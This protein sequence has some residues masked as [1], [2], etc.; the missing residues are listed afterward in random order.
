MDGAGEKEQ[1]TIVCRCMDR[2]QED[3]VRAVQMAVR[4]FGPEALEINNYRRLALA[5]TGFCQGRGCTSLVQRIFAGEMKKMDVDI[6]FDEVNYRVRSPLQ[7][8]PL[9]VFAKPSLE[10]V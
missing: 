8:V 4:M 5:T 9:G 10:E 6:S 1:P 7:P 3:L 2:T